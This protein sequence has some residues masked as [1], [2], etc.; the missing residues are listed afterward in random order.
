VQA[1][2]ADAP[3]FLRITWSSPENLGKVIHTGGWPGY[4]PLE[5]KAYKHDNTI[6]TRKNI[7]TASE[8]LLPDR[9]ASRTNKA[10]SQGRSVAHF[11]V[12]T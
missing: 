4:R 6:V 2:V 10:Q 1:L 8:L 7:K 5:G 11:D 3:D 9:F 12:D